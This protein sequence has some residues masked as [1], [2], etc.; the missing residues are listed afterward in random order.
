M[1]TQDHWA[2]VVAYTS[3]HRIEGLL[4]LLKGERLSDKLNVAERAFEPLREARVYALATGELVHRAEHLAL[5]K[6][7][8][9]L[10]L[11]ASAEGEDA[12]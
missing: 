7:H 8:L 11:P 12:P 10:M 5:N 9:A 4:L 1:A 2:P 6:N 3:T